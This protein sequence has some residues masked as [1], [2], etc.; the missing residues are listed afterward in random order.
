MAQKKTV[1]TK[2][3]AVHKSTAPKDIP[4]DAIPLIL[5]RRIALVFITLVVV[6]LLT[7]LYLATMQAIIHVT[8]N[9]HEV[10]T[11]FVVRTVQTATTDG[12]VQGE[13]HSGTLGRKKTFTPSGESHQNVDQQAAGTVTLFNTS[14]SAQPLVA[15]TRLLSKDGV[16]FRLKAGVTVPAKGSV[17][18][19][20]HADQKGASGNIGPTAFTIPGLNAAKQSLIYA[21]SAAPMT[22]GVKPISVL[23]Q[24]QIN[25]AVTQ[26]KN[27]LVEDA[28]GMLRD[29]RQRSYT[30]EVFFAD[31]SSQKISAKGG[32]HVDSFDIELQV[33]VT[34]VFYDSDALQKITERKL[35]EGLAQG[36]MF[37]D[38]GAS[39]RQISVSS[40]D[41]S[42]GAA[43][44]QVRQVA[45]AIV[46]RSSHA[47]DVGSFVGLS[48][49]Q[50]QEIIMQ[51]NVAT[52][53]KVEFF[54]FW[55]KHVPRLKDH[56]LI[57]IR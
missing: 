42:K 50:V 46:S 6:A 32:D 53:V 13:I 10:K 55:V 34:G 20:V 29:Q 40:V 18:A 28:K 51:A 43:T 12:E 45:K 35:S 27:E 16:L 39:G 9:P 57:D 52:D 17:E 2:R 36:E 24:E 4:A 31:V 8:A 15:T 47:L 19:Q 33:A 23:S 1:K 41:A 14:A 21:T 5:Y 37:V 11:D 38:T 22:G 44:I 48:A 25:G 3:I 30:G 56:I 7:V 49:A 26:L 54:P